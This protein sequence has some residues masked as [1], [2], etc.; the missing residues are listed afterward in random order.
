[1]VVV[2]VVVRGTEGGE[3]GK[4]DNKQCNMQAFFSITYHQ[5]IGRSSI[6][7]HIP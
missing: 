7:D 1:V 6:Y 4:N 5:R 2:V 3:E